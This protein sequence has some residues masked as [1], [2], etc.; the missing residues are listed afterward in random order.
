MKDFGTGLNE[1]EV[2]DL[3]DY[4]DRNRDGSLDYNEFILSLRVIKIL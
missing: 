2:N 4:F 3:F 1:K